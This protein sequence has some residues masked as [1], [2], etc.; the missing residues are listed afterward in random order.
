MWWL[1]LSQHSL[2]VVVYRWR[3]LY[4]SSKMVVLRGDELKVGG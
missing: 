2:T 1:F 3:W 4:S